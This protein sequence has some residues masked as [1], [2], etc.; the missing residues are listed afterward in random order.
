MVKDGQLDGRTD[1]RIDTGL[2]M[3]TWTIERRGENLIV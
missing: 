3:E 1:R 2:L